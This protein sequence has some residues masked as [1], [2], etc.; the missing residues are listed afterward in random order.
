M[1]LEMKLIVSGSRHIVDKTEVY[2]QLDRIHKEHGITHVIHGG[3]RGVD[4]LAGGWAIENDIPVTVY[5]AEWQ[6][7]GRA[8][9]PVRNGKM[10][11]SKPDRWVAFP[12]EGS[13]GTK[14][15]IKQA[16]KRGIP[17]EIIELTTQ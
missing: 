17:G 8:A 14:D 7:Y 16:A 9:G 12:V 10:L 11:D 3:A 13:V 2:R 4:S 5:K 1:V 6:K 15:F